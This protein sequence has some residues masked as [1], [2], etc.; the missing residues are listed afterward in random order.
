MLQTI[1]SD[2]Q[3][4]H[5]PDVTGRTLALCLKAITGQAFTHPRWTDADRAISWCKRYECFAVCR[6]ILNSA[7]Q[8]LEEDSVFQ[9]FTVAANLNEVSAG[10]RILLQ[11][12]KIEVF[13]RSNPD[14]RRNNPKPKSTTLRPRTTWK[15]NM[16]NGIPAPWLLALARAEETA[17]SKHPFPKDEAAKEYWMTLA[18][19]FL[20]AFDSELRAEQRMTAIEQADHD[21][22][23]DPGSAA[24]PRS[25]VRPSYLAP[26]TLEGN[27]VEDGEDSVDSAD[28]FTE[29][30]VCK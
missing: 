1:D 22:P 14:R 20:L 2:D 15:L 6:T 11:G 19:A 21:Q 13:N 29:G 5:I 26:F 25:L 4:A 10:H 3:S 12:W 30:N 8:S 23:C 17:D 24:Y 7:V 18:T 28:R 27:E 16:A 9:A